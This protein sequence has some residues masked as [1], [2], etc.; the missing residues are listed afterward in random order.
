MYNI[1]TCYLYMDKNYYIQAKNT[2][3]LVCL[4]SIIQI[5]KEIPM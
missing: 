2:N 4:S 3:I 1:G 5:D